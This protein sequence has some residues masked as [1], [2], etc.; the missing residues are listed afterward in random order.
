[1]QKR[2]LKFRKV[3]LNI[4]CYPLILVSNNFELAASYLPN[5]VVKTITS[6]EKKN[7]FNTELDEFHIKEKNLFIADNKNTNQESV[8]VSEII[9]EG[10]ENHPEGRKLEL[11]AYD[12]MSIKP[13]SVVNNQILNRDLKSIYATGWFSDVKVK[14]Q[15]G[16]LGVNL[17]EILR[18]CNYSNAF[19]SEANDLQIL[20]AISGCYEEYKILQL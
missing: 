15:D 16:P 19:I 10:W 18:N 5:D 3:Y 6:I 9:I 14:S 2:F 8:L 12:S 11:A 20:E 7:I 1:M 4:A 13:G 17:E